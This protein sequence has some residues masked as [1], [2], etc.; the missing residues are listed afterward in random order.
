MNRT[1]NPKE[2]IK[3]ALSLKKILNTAR[4]KKKIVFT[5]GCFDILH[6]GHIQ[7]LHR[8]KKLGDLLVVAV[9]SDQSVRKL[10][11]KN[12]PINSLRDR[13]EVLAGLESIDFVTSFN[14]IDPLQI[15][16]MLQPHVLVKG[17]DWKTSQ[18]IG[19]K[20]VLSRGGKVRSLRFKQGRSTTKIIERAKS[21]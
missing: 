5:N 10:K 18:I 19:A 14:Q 4:K 6:S 7:Y 3:T 12:R 20:E 9:N 8:A 11:G 16:L 21:F 15:I 1:R 17:G 13:M 2:K